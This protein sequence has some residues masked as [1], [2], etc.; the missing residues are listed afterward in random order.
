MPP[1]LISH[2]IK[3]SVRGMKKL[4]RVLCFLPKD[5]GLVSNTPVAAYNFFK[6]Q[7][8]DKKPSLPVYPGT[9]S[10]WCTDMEAVKH[11]YK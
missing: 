5:P 2:H 9:A 1:R 6:H 3:T 11:S 10:K 7:L 4:M 8:Q